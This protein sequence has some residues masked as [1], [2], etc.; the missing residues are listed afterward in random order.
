MIAAL[1]LFW[2]ILSGKLTAEIALFGLAVTLL[3]WL[4]LCRV[5]GWSARRELL[6]YRL[7]PHAAAYAAVLL[8]E[9]LKSSLAVLPYAF[10]RRPNGVVAEFDSRLKTPAANAALAGSITLTPGTVTISVKD[11]HFT[12]HCLSPDFADGLGTSAFVRRLAKMEAVAAGINKKE[13]GRR[14]K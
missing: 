2:L 12:V 5:L 13:I 10:G 3:A 11:G 8:W 6:F 9:I 7:A 4:F 14:K 1:F